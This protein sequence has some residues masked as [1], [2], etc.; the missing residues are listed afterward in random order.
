MFFFMM[1]VGWIGIYSEFFVFFQ[2]IYVNVQLIM[3][4]SRTVLVGEKD[5]S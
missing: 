1:V 4:K 3:C 2:N 5:N